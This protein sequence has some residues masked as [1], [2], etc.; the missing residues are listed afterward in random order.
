MDEN[1]KYKL[2]NIASEIITCDV[3]QV[4]FIYPINITLITV[5]RGYE[6]KSIFRFLL[7]YVI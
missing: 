4:W 6:N 3:K 1:T 7:N 2:P 5:V